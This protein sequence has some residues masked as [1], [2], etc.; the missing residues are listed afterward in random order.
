MMSKTQESLFYRLNGQLT[1]VSQHLDSEDK[2][3]AL[4]A[5]GV[6]RKDLVELADTFLPS[7]KRGSITLVE[8]LMAAEDRRKEYKRIMLQG[9]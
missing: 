7:N 8:S 3:E 9:K 1:W 5:I 6:L 2:S 4:R